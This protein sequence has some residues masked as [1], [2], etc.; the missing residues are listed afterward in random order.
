MRGLFRCQILT[1]AARVEREGFVGRRD[2]HDAVGDHGRPLKLPRVGYGHDPLRRQPRHGR[3]VDLRERRIPVAARIAV[4]RR[5]RRLGSHRTVAIA[6]AP[7]QVHPLVVCLQLQI[8]EALAEHEAVERPAVGRLHGHPDQ[9]ALSRPL[10]RPEELHEVRHFR[11]GDD[12][13]RHALERLPLSDEFHQLLIV[14]RRQAFG[15]RRSHFASAAVGAVAACASALERPPSGIDGLREEGRT[16]HEEARKGHNAAS[17]QH[18]EDVLPFPQVMFVDVLPVRQRPT[19]VLERSRSHDLHS[20]AGPRQEVLPELSSATSGPYQSC[21]EER[22]RSPGAFPAATTERPLWFSTI[23][24]TRM[25]GPAYEPPPLLALAL[26]GLRHGV[27]GTAP[28][29]LHGTKDRR[30]P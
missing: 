15:D 12:I 26:S 14:E 1:A 30:C 22:P 18:V 10:D 2:V 8:V 6:G 17:H 4:V 5:P 13:R 11:V 28:G 3:L 7:Q 24:P 21:L 23:Q 27:Q 25:I 20:P 29:R 9:R 16:R 19:E